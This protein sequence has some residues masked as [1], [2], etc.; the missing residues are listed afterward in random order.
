MRTEKFVAT[1]GKK[2]TPEYQEFPGSVLLYEDEEL[3]I[4]CDAGLQT[5]HATLLNQ[6]VKIRAMDAQ[7]QAAVEK[8]PASRLRALAKVNPEV[9][10]RLAELLK[11][12]SG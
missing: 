11:E 3:G 9:A 1:T 5:E 7:R 8:S 4:L 6:I 12:F 2:G 10:T